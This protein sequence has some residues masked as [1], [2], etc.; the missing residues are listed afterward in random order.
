M[1]RLFG[2]EGYVVNDILDSLFRC[3]VTELAKISIEFRFSPDHPITN[4]LSL[5]EFKLQPIIFLLHH[6][7]WINVY[8]RLLKTLVTLTRPRL[9]TLFTPVEFR[10]EA[11]CSFILYKVWCFYSLFQEPCTHHCSCQFLSKSFQFILI[12]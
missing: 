8:R 2:F 5:A 3:N 4:S 6:Y 1:F 9:L 11:S 12:L 7:R 10:V